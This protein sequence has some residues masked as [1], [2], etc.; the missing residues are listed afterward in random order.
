VW[1]NAVTHFFSLAPGADN[2]TGLPDDY[3]A[4]QL[5]PAALQSSDMVTGGATG[6]FIDL[7]VVTAAGTILGSQFS[8]VSNIE[9]INLSSG[10]NNITLVDSLV[11]GASS[12]YFAVVDG[13]GSDTIDAGG[14]S[15]KPIV[16]FAAGGSDT[17]KGGHGDDA[18]AIAA[19]DLTSTDTI[20]G[21]AGVDNLYFSTTGT[22]TASALTNVSGI[23]GLVLANGTNSV[24]LTNGLVDNPSIGYV[25]VAG[26]TGDDTVDASS[27]SNGTP[28]A[29]FG[30]GGGND[31][32]T[33]GNGNDS[34]LFASGQLTAADI[35]SGGGG[36][37][38]L[39]ITT[40][41][42][43]NAAALTHVSGIEG[44]FLQHGGTFNLADGI[45]AA[46]TLAAVGSA[47]VD[48][49]DGSAVTA[50]GITFV[51]NG[52]A[53]VLKGGSKD[54][55]FFIAD[56][57]FAAVDGNGGIDRI[58]LTDGSSSFNL[59]ANAAKIHDI[60]VILMDGVE[61]G[62]VTLT[63]ANI[64]QIS[65]N[66][67]LYIVGDPGDS[68]SSGNGYTQIASGVTNNAVAPG[69]SFFEFQHASGSILYIDSFMFDTQNND[70]AVDV[71]PENSPVSR[72]VY[73]DHSVFPAGT[74]V[75]HTLSG[76]DAGSFNIDPATGN[77][78]FK[79]PPDFEN[80]QDQDHNNHYEFAVITS[81]DAAIPDAT[82]F[83]T[84]VVT[85][86][87]ENAALNAA[88]AANNLL[89]F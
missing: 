7:I 25:A 23:E 50:Y 87:N 8:G 12:G 38:T 79:S 88:I 46:A 35:V 27:V 89:L 1:S 36:S 51:G 20:Q 22:I 18:I 39:W 56:N 43:T 49:F 48:T 30:S 73:S 76:P 29:F 45:T 83:V 15:A 41:G 42:T 28:I 60:E 71:A 85:D 78:T 61:H 54:D 19:A 24:T 10:G 53:D 81:N 82:R 47:A 21:D 86:V 13:G 62:N 44:V 26:G 9:Q 75:N 72:V 77:V 55:S 70:P 69:H 3:N 57:G 5:T 17:F 67:T 4:F 74:I 11:L 34:F 80:P 65:G 31:T 58:S 64:A 37:D 32:F 84:S 63:G 16:F 2:F 68:Y 52:G 40:A 6:S 59:T 33:G 14:I 66:N